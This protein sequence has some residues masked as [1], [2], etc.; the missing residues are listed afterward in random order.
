MFLILFFML[1]GTL[2]FEDIFSNS[3]FKPRSKSCDV[4]INVTNLFCFLYSGIDG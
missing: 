1:L 4:E 2:S 3:I